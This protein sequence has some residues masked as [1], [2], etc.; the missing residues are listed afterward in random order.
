MCDEMFFVAPKV[1]VYRVGLRIRFWFL[2][3]F[4]W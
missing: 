2:I 3:P 1:L 4:V